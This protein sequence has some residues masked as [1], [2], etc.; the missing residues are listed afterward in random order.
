MSGTREKPEDLL[1]VAAEVPL[2]TVTQAFPLVEANEALL[3][4]NERRMNAAGVIE[5]RT[6]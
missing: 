2:R 1:N 6:G 4:L 5:V 3:T